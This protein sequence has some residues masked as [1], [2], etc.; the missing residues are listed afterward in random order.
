MR[1]W[2]KQGDGAVFD[3]ERR[4]EGHHN[5]NHNN[6]ELQSLL[7]SNKQLTKRLEEE[8]SRRSELEKQIEE[9]R[10]QHSVDLACKDS[11]IGFFRDEAKRKEDDN[12]RLSDEL[13]KFAGSNSEARLREALT[14]RNTTTAELRGAIASVEVLVEEARRELERA[15]LRERRAA[16]ERLYAALS[17]ED[18]PTLESVIEQSRAAGLDA[19]DIEKAEAKLAELRAMSPEQRAAKLKNKQDNATKKEA[20]Q[21]VKKDDIEALR[22]LIESLEP[23]CRWQDWKDYAGRSLWKCAQDLHAVRVQKFLAPQV[24]APAY[25]KGVDPWKPMRVPRPLDEPRL[26]SGLKPERLPRPADV[27]GA[28]EA[29]APAAIANRPPPP[30]R[31]ATTGATP[32][33]VKDQGS[34][35]PSSG[36]ATPQASEIKRVS[37]A[38][39]FSDPELGEDADELKVHTVGRQIS[40][41]GLQDY[42][43]LR[44]KAL[45]AVAQDD[46]EAISEVLEQVPVSVWSQWKNKAGQDLLTLSEVRRSPDTYSAIASALGVLKEL[47]REPFEEREAVW[48]FV[49]GEVQPRRATVQ[50]DTPEDADSVLVEFWDDDQP[51]TYVERCLVRKIG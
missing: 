29:E 41:P 51:A 31:P 5:H 17:Q 16:F 30:K 33:V 37:V 3:D 44:A 34:S 9:L 43:R 42:A 7:Q 1:S 40:D 6:Q 25:P 27:L 20:F 26:V 8:Q 2:R 47:G 15:E 18:E 21:F 32:S 22:E 12:Q 14:N 4:N 11:D 45:R 49:D 35:S 50:E 46:A 28:D 39:N 13:L 23:G 10:E 38:R 36:S 24:A 48:V 19:E